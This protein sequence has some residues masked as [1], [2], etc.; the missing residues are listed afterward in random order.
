MGSHVERRR[1]RDLPSEDKR[2]H[3]AIRCS[4]AIGINRLATNAKMRKNE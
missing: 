4:P 2:V 1:K 3:D